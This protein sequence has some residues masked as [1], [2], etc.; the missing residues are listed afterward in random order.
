M[1]TAMRPIG[2]TSS[3]GYYGDHEGWLDAIGQHRDSD[4]LT[5]SN[6]RCFVAE[7]DAIDPEGED[8]AV[9]SFRHWAVGWMEELLCRP[10]SECATLADTLR[11]RLSDYPVLNEDEWS[12]LENEE[13][14]NTTFAAVPSAWGSDEER[15]EIASFVVSIDDS[16]NYGIE[17]AD[18]Y[19]P[20]DRSLFFG[21]LAYKRYAHTH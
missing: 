7:L 18:N 1:A 19:W 17:D 10:D 20:S 3:F 16:G 5:R 6:F 12:A 21:L 9:E 4:I 14:Q 13:N 8:H 15:R 11:E 2:S